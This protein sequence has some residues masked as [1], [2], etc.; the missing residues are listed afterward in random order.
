MTRD[1]LMIAG[2]LILGV[3]IFSAVLQIRVERDLRALE[4]NHILPAAPR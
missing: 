1:P 2:L 4:A 3:L